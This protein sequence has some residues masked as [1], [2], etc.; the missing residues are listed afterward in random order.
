M[1]TTTTNRFLESGKQLIQQELQALQDCVRTLDQDFI[2]AC[3]TIMAC[4]GRVIVTGVGKSGH[5]GRKIAATLASTGTPAYFVH[6][7]E[8][9]HGDF[10][11]ITNDDVMIMISYSGEA[12]EIIT[13]LPMI[14][15]LD[16]PTITMS[17]N[18][19]STMGQ[20]A[21]IF[22]SIEV[23]FEACPLRLAP[24]SSTT[25]TLV[26]GDALAVAVL[27]E[28]GFSSEDFAFSHPGGKLGRKLLLTVAD[29]MHTGTSIPLVSSQ[30]TIAQT[31]V[32][33]SA[34]GFGLSGVQHETEQKL[35]GIFT[36]GDLRRTLEHH[37]ALTQPITAVM[38]TAYRYVHSNTLAVEALSIMETHKITALMVVNAQY[39]PLGII[40]LH[41][42]LDA[43]IT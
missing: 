2:R 19:Q 21:Q 37:V 39:Q 20:H 14:K 4:T 3:E 28:K 22:L 8:A 6:P 7:T 40:H 23:P 15:R 25:K 1:N 33:M 11:L 35:M 43:K 34:K 41:D 18:R 32:E 13:L 16:I 12:E 24:T 10:G 29:L 38:T 27:T 5:I 26:L 30:A 42:L 9:C 31:L 36:D 17:G